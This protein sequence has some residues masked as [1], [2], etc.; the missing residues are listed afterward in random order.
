MGKVSAVVRVGDGEPT[1]ALSGVP[2]QKEAR[3]AAFSLMRLVE[4][5]EGAAERVQAAGSPSHPLP[6]SSKKAAPGKIEGP[7]AAKARGPR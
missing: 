4:M 7:E 1:F 5:I 3:L 2:G 6:R